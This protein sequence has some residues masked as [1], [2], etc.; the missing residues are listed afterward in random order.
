MSTAE[1]DLS[2]NGF[3]AS[4]DVVASL[5][6][7]FAEPQSGRRSRSARILPDW[8]SQAL[9]A[10]A[11]VAERPPSPAS[12]PRVLREAGASPRFSTDPKREMAPHSELRLSGRAEMPTPKVRKRGRCNCGGC[13]QC[14]DNARWD[15]IFDE[16]FNDPTY[17][18]A[19][20]VR[21]SSTL[22]GA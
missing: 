20:N 7:Q 17:Y 22:A 18:G 19:L 5:M 11:P 4:A 12:P 15:R 9:A 3:L 10:P 6:T 14:L 21:H 1:I 8:L 2:V 13:P 16:K